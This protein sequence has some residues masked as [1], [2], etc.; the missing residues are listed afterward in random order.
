[1][2][3]AGVRIPLRVTALAFGGDDLKERILDALHEL[4]METGAGI[5]KRLI[6]QF[7]AAVFQEHG[8]DEMLDKLLS[9]VDAV[10][11]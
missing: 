9:E 7:L 2:P 6:V 8:S 5:T 1:M 4:H 3:W 11:I 10:N